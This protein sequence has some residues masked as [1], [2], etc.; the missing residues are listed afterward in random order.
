MN[1]VLG[2]SSAAV[3]FDSGI[4]GKQ[5][6]TEMTSRFRIAIA[7]AAIALAAGIASAS[8]PPSGPVLPAKKS[9]RLPAAV[10]ASDYVTIESRGGNTSVLAR[11]PV[12]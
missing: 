4:P 1:A 2:V 5:G 6:D 12:Y 10:V 11:V 3:V 8:T 7:A 9:D